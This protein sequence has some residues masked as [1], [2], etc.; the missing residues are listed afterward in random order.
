MRLGKKPVC[1]NAHVCF[2]THVLE[3]YGYRENAA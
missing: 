2:G 3:A 1:E